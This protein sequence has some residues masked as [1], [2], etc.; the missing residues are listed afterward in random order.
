MKATV[1]P[2]SFLRRMDNSE[3]DRL[4]RAGR[5]WDEA[6]AARIKISERELQKQIVNLLNQRDIWHN[7]SRMDKRATNRRGTPDFLFFHKGRAQAW[8]VK[9]GKA[10]LSLE[11]ID[12][13][14]QMRRNGWHVF[15]VRSLTQAQELLS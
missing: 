10:E 8:E 5:T 15:V 4:G 7:R 3:R 2:D 13:H 9:I 12:C 14:L 1:L 6:E 11:Q